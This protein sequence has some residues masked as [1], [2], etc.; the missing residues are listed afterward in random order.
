MLEVCHSQS[1]LHLHRACS[2]NLFG[3]QEKGVYI[4]MYVYL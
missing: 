3:E 2:K 1:I 4:Y